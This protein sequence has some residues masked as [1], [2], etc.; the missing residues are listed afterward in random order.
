MGGPA[1]GGGGPSLVVS[2]DMSTA[3]EHPAAS[4]RGR[5]WSETVTVRL[6]ETDA[7]GTLAVGALCDYLQEAAGNHAGSHGVS[8]ARLKERH[9]TWVLSRLR[10]RIDRLPSAGEHLEVR[11]WSTGVERLFALRDF[12]VL[13]AQGRRIA[14]AVSA[15]L[16]LDTAARR[17]VR[18][19]SVFDPPGSGETPR[20]LD[21]GIEK[22]PAL[23]EPDRETPLI[24]R[25]SDLDANAHA[26]NARIAEWVVEGVGRDA[27]QRS[28]I[29]GLDV[30]FLAEAL[31]GDSVASRAAAMADGRFL[32]SLVRA[33][34]GREIA[35]ARTFWKPREGSG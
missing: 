11:T 17:P 18:I 29:R 8:I 25:L 2:G 4:Q 33:A 1:G 19:Q 30:D 14:A 10:L 15:W 21:A 31:L 7:H 5:T 9:L 34:D 3:S 32:H 23:E 20:A 26:N 16:I 24:V 13:D 27:W 12:A 6:I 22:L 35:R 28:L